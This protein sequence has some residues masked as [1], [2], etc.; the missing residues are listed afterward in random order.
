MC[1]SGKGVRGGE[2]RGGNHA[3]TELGMQAQL[4]QPCRELGALVGHTHKA[5]KWEQKVFG[6]GGSVEN[7]LWWMWDTNQSFGVCGLRESED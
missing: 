1:L 3:N 2:Q 4:S 7:N 5:G 6:R